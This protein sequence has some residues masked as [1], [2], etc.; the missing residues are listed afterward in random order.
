LLQKQRM[1]LVEGSASVANAPE[2]TP[3]NFSV[4]S[5]S[6][7]GGTYQWA[8]GNGQTATGA[9]VTYAYPDDGVFNATV[10]HTT[11][12]G[13]VGVFTIPITITNVAP[14]ADAGPD[15]TVNE[16]TVVSFA[17]AFTDPGTA[18]TF[19]HQWA[20]TGGAAT[21]STQNVN[22]T[23]ADDEVVTA[24]YRVTD[25]DNGLGT[26]TATVTVANVAPTI[27][28]TPSAVGTPG[29]QYRYTLTFTDPGVNDTHTCSSP[30]LPSGATFGSCVLTWTPAAAQ[31]V[32]VQLC[33]TD[34]DSGQTCQTFPIV[35]GVPDSDADGL[36]DTWEQANFGN[37]SQTPTGDPDADGL[38]NAAELAGV[39]DPNLFD[40]P[41]APTIASAQCGVTATNLR[42]TL[43]VTNA[44]DPQADTL[45]Y[46]FEVYADVA[47]TQLDDSVSGLTAGTGTTSWRISTPMTPGSHHWRARAHDGKAF[48]PWSSPSCT[49]TIPAPPT[50]DRLPTAPSISAPALGSRVAA[51]T[52]ALEVGNAT[53]QD[54]DTM[55]YEFEIFRGATRVGTQASVAQGTG[56]TSWTVTPALVEDGLYTWRARAVTAGGAGPWSATG[57]FGV[58]TANTA[59]PVPALVSPQNGTV[60]DALTPRFSFVVA[61]D[62]DGD[63]LTF[64]WE[65]SADNTFATALASDPALASTSIA[66]PSALTEDTRYCWRVRSDDGQATSAWAHACFV[67]SAADAAPSIPTPINPAGGAVVTTT[68][69]VFAWTSATD[70]EGDS[71]T[72]EL[73]VKQ[74][75]AVVATL[76]GI[77]GNAALAPLALE[78]GKTFTWRVRATAGG[79]SSE[80]SADATFEVKLLV[81]PEP[82]TPQGCGCATSP[83][84]GFALA[85]LLLGLRRRRSQ[86]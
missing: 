24:T 23:W 53:D 39:T 72:Y 11:P 85:L 1:P 44:T 61:A 52:P 8:F 70:P 45:T 74:G 84:A 38:N 6:V 81:I 22:R 12:V 14:T 13:G 76:T 5:S 83:G 16:G 77:S 43:T 42:P 4:T 73:E 37:L 17:G 78:D 10:T 28:S 66:A 30:Q 65:L 82:V 31:S 58:N 86:V 69:P 18:D 33:V 32:S 59:P 51:L 19:T 80:Y 25:D 60:A 50:V 75:G 40:G 64:D 9:N 20:F 26:D 54:G 34:D 47:L 57:S 46:Q 41:T 79:A 71:I 3:I 27:T 68:I 36:P 21:A 48:G 67:V 7:A 2:G 29:V 63:A 49:F 15:R 56:T 55:T 35:V 62:A